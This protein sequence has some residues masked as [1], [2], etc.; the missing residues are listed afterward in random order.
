MKLTPY[1][2]KHGLNSWLFAKKTGVSQPEIWRIQNEKV[3]PRLD[4]ALKIIDVCNG[5]VSINDLLPSKCFE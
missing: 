5:E 1:F 3:V 2:K 4:T